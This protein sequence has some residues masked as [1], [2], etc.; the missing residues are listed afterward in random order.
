MR[1]NMR[2]TKIEEKDNVVTAHF[3]NGETLTADVLIGCDGIHSVTRTYV[4]GEDSNPRF[5][6]A[7]VILGLTKVTPEEIKSAGIESGFHVW[8]GHG[9]T[10]GCY[11]C[12]PDGIWGW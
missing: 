11:P 5:T 12:S 9:T 6:G 1:Y 2:L 7:S 10:F 4:L 3:A 8:T